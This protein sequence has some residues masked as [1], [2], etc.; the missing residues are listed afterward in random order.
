[1]GNIRQNIFTFPDCIYIEYC[2]LADIYKFSYV[3]QQSSKETFPLSVCVENYQ[4]CSARF[5]QPESSS[6][7]V[8]SLYKIEVIY[9][10]RKTLLLYLL[11]K[12]KKQQNYGDG[13]R[14]VPLRLVWT[15]CG[16]TSQIFRV[17]NIKGVTLH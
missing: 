3:I 13:C 12:K 7:H 17:T 4:G 1:V 15:V 11:R 10:N 6:T 14:S 9:I 8:I 2:D 16:V 5:S